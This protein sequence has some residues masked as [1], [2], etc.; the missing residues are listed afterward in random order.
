MMTPLT[1]KSARFAA[2]KH[3]EIIYSRQIKQIVI[4]LLQHL[5]EI[6][7]QLFGAADVGNNSWTIGQISPIKKKAVPSL[8]VTDASH[9]NT[10]RSSATQSPTR[11]KPEYLMMTNIQT[12]SG[13]SSPAPIPY[14]Q[15][16]NAVPQRFG[17]VCLIRADR[18]IIVSRPVQ[19]FY[20]NR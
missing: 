7:N 17:G 9:Q 3:D 6:R 11:K 4:A 15:L 20:A 10:H 16:I 5:A 13:P 2:A 14:S 18:L 19:H 12:P 8:P 1:R